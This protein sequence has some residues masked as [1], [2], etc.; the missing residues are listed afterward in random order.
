MKTITINHVESSLPRWAVEFA[1]AMM[2]LSAA[3]SPTEVAQ[4]MYDHCA[5][6]KAIINTVGDLLFYWALWR[7][8]KKLYKPLSGWWV[9][10]FALVMTGG[11]TTLLLQT[12]LWH[13]TIEIVGV[14]VAALLPMVYIPLGV[15]LLLYY[16]GALA[17]VGPWMIG[18]SIVA[19]IMPVVWVLM[20]WENS[21][22][23]VDTLF[24]LTLI[25]YAYS[26]RRVLRAKN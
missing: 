7:G 2:L 8:M 14:V 12:G 18:H 17:H 5:W 3:L 23:I 22:W 1:F 11:L 19:S 13:D 20:G 6:V 25:G 16:N 21:Y 4:W 9:A 24:F 10:L 15:L 26:L